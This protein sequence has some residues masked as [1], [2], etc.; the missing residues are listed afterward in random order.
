MI[1]SCSERC[2]HSWL[3]VLSAI[4]SACRISSGL[5]RI[6][7]SIAASIGCSAS[8]RSRPELI[9]RTS[10]TK[11]NS[12]AWASQMPVL[13][14]VAVLPPVLR[15]STATRANFSATGTVSSSSTCGQAPITTATSSF[16]PI[17][18]KNRPSN[19]SRN[20]LMSSSTW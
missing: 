15:T 17:V 8:S 19:R 16:M 12:P 7:S 14:A 10:S 4:R 9:A 20:G 6:D 2:I 11:A 3:E 18:M 13:I 5:S 1:C